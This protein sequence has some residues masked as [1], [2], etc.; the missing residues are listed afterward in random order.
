MN[1]MRSHVRSNGFSDHRSEPSL[2]D[3]VIVGGG[4]AGLTAATY[5]ARYRRNIVL[6]D[7]GESRAALIPGSHNY[8]GF[9]GIAGRALLARLQDQVKQY[10]VTI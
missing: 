8:P 6:I 1:Q 5:L 10:G 3:C 2:L 7:A 4:P 9:P